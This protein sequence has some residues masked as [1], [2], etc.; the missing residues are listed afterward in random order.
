MQEV[1]NAKLSEIRAR[2]DSDNYED[3]KTIYQE[4]KDI[5][6]SNP[7]MIKDVLDTFDYCLSQEHTVS[8]Q[9]DDYSYD[10]SSVDVSEAMK[11]LR[12]INNVADDSVRHEIIDVADSLAYVDGSGSYTLVEIADM[13]IDNLAPS[14]EG[15]MYAGGFLS[16]DKDIVVHS[17]SVI[18]DMV[19]SSHCGAGTVECITNDLF[20]LSENPKFEDSALVIKEV[21]DTLDY[22]A[23]KCL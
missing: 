11:A 4:L 22:I 23:K 19:H 16:E 17:M 6:L 3:V 21:S 5:A 10:V 7:D 8:R 9:E 12:L 18:K 13:I 2:A 15:G 20:N 1:Y 14:E